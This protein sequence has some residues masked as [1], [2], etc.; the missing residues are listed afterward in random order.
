MSDPSKP[1]STPSPPRV[2]ILVVD[3]DK[4]ITRMLEA[5]LSRALDADIIIA[6]A[7]FGVMNTIASE[8]PKVVLLDVMM[9]GLD[10]RSLTALIRADADLATTR[11]VLV[12]AM[13]ESALAKLSD[14]CGADD[15]VPKG[16]RPTE[17]ARR[18]ARWLHA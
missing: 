5:M 14:A 4:T 12:S 8:R 3:D 10:G 15:Y 6:N 11:I 18:I 2:R 7:A 17:V 1:T 13:D 16:L 9:P